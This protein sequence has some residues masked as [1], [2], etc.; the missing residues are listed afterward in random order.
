MIITNPP[1]GKRIGEEVDNLYKKIGDTFKK[2]FPGFNAWILSSNVSA[3]KKLHLKPSEKIDL[4]NGA[5]RVKFCKY[6]LK[7]GKYLE[8]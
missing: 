8:E 3:L 6:N 5:L 2:K 7:E 1:Y 4:F